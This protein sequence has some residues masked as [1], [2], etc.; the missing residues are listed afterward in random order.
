MTKL[1]EVRKNIEA[2]AP[3]CARG[4]FRDLKITI[5]EWGEVEEYAKREVE[6]RRAAKR[7]ATEEAMI[8]AP[9]RSIVKR[10]GGRE[11]P[12]SLSRSPETSPV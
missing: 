9:G 2:G 6:R 12:K 11:A 8:R 5:D 4:R 1:A 7:V 10:T 3:P